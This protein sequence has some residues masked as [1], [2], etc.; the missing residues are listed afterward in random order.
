MTVVRVED[1][2]VQGIE[3]L[4]FRISCLGFRV[5]GGFWVEGLGG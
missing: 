1:L 5:F 2:G 4:G 3:G